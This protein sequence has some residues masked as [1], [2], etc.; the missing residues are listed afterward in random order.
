M[1]TGTKFSP[2]TRTVKYRVLA[3]EVPGTRTVKYRSKIPLIFPNFP[4]IESRYS[5]LGKKSVKNQVFG[6]NFS[7][8]E[9]L[10]EFGKK[11]WKN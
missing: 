11:T 3:L 5:Q 10:V 6:T 2:G 4:Y 7:K 8:Q 9:K 1:Y